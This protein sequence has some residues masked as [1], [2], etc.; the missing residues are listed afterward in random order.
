MKGLIKQQKSLLRRLVQCGDFVRGSINCVCGRCN[1]AN[2]I[3]EKKSAAKAY[4]LTYKDGLQQ[5]KIVYLAKNRLRVARTASQRTMSH[6][7]R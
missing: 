1:R 5:T 4:R 6:N 3:C 7:S 2:C